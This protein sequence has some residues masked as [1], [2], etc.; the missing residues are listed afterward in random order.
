MNIHVVLRKWHI[1]VGVLLALP[2]IVVC[3]TAMLMA[4]NQN[5]DLRNIELNLAWLP[6]YQNSAQPDLTVSNMEIRATLT[7]TD[8]RNFIGTRFGLWQLD[9]NRLI[10]VTEV[11]P[12]EIRSIR[13]TLNGLVLASRKGI[14]LNEHNH[15]RRIFRG[16]TWAVEVLPNQT[17]RIAAKNKGLL[18]SS[19]GG[20]QWTPRRDLNALPLILPQGVPQEEMNLGRLVLDLHTGRAWFGKQWAWLW[21]DCF[22]VILAFLALSGLIMKSRVRTLKAKS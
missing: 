8:N 10:P 9:H 7:T 11:P 20:K 3:M 22:A 4:H 6:G 2:I 15:W 19:D 13:E 21:I 5:L 18:E 16:D 17:L 14:W 12:V 1:N